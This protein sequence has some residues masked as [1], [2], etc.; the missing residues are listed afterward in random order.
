[1][2]VQVAGQVSEW[3]YGHV[4]ESEGLAGGL[5]DGLAG[6]LGECQLKA[7]NVYP[8]IATGSQLVEGLAKC[9]GIAK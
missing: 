6:G 9:K 8:L 2:N 5:T 3:L 4:F 1:M 7:L